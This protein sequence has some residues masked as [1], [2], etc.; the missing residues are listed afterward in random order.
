MQVFWEFMKLARKINAL[1]NFF[2]KMLFENLV[3]F[4][5]NLRITTH[6]NV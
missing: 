2:Y 1:S 5:M 4:N 6:P 3:P